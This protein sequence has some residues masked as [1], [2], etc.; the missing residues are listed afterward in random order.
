MNQQLRKT[1]RIAVLLGVLSSPCIAQSVLLQGTIAITYL[2]LGSG[3]TCEYQATVNALSAPGAPTTWAASLQA[4]QANDDDGNGV[5]AG[6]TGTVSS[7]GP[8]CGSLPSLPVVASN[9][10]LNISSGWILSFTYSQWSFIVGLG[11]GSQNPNENPPS[12]AL[13]F[14]PGGVGSIQ[15]TNAGLVVSCSNPSVNYNGC[16]GSSGGPGPGVVISA[17]VC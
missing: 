6:L 7:A 3:A 8:L 13:S 15:V 1:A 16:G 2:N 12:P 11:P 5:G 9:T 17:L 14:Y 10:P 4:L